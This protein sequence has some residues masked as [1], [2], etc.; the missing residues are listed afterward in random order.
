MA[1]FLLTWNPDGDG[2][3]EESHLEEMEGAAVGQ[4]DADQWSTGSRKSGI[5]EGDR[6]LLSREVHERGFLEPG[7]SGSRAT[8][9]TAR[10]AADQQ[11]PGLPRRP[12]HRALPATV[13]CQPTL[14]HHQ[15]SV[16]WLGTLSRDALT[17]AATSTMGAIQTVFRSAAVE[18]E[19]RGLLTALQPPPNGAQPHRKLR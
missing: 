12:Y 10:S 13:R 18:A 16:E 3:P 5:S 15:R 7:T 14:V 1:V 9:R 17:Q 11:A 8:G 2:W 19:L 6:A 4:I